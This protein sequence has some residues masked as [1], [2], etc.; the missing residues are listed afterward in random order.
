VDGKSFARSG[1]AKLTFATEDDYP[2][3]GV[4]LDIREGINRGSKIVS[5]TINTDIRLAVAYNINTRLFGDTSENS[6][7]NLIP[8]ITTGN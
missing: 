6:S 1:D 2:M 7:S 3:R 5:P 8:I 4:T